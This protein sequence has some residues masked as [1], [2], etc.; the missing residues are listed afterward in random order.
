[1]RRMPIGLLPRCLAFCASVLTHTTFRAEKLQ[2]LQGA[3]EI[4]LVGI[5]RPRLLCVSQRATQRSGPLALRKPP[6][7]YHRRGHGQNIGLPGLCEV[8]ARR[9][10][11]IVRREQDRLPTDLCRQYRVPHQPKALMLEIQLCTNGHL[12]VAQAHPHQEIDAPRDR[13]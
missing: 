1:M 2:S 12:H 5:W 9:R 4:G 8:I 13:Q 10:K 6:G 11:R 7:T 3:D